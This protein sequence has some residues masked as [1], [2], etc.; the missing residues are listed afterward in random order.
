MHTTEVSDI[1]LRIPKTFMH[2]NAHPI[3]P[4]QQAIHLKKQI[5]HQESCLGTST[6]L[7]AEEW[8]V[9]LPSHEQATNNAACLESSDTAGEERSVEANLHTWSIPETGVGNVVGGR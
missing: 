3:G 6:E 1:G 7:I 2:C 4:L 9:V 8:R 5:A